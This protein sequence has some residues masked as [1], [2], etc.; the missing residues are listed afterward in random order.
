MNGPATHP[1]QRSPGPVRHRGLWILVGVVTILIAGTAAATGA[2]VAAIERAEVIRVAVNEHGQDGVN[3]D[4][5]LPAGILGAGLAVLPQV[6]P[7][8]ARAEAQLQIGEW[9]PMATA[10]ADDL[11]AA[12]DFTL[13][14]VDDDGEHVEVLKEGRHLIVHVRSADADVDVQVPLALVGRTLAA[15]GVS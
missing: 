6:M 4:I 3:F 8:E 15:L 10:L 12:G 13:V 11:A 5:A 2:A 7:E 9:G 14:E 1:P